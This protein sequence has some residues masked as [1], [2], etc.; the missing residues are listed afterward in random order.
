MTLSTWNLGNVTIRSRHPLLRL[1]A[2]LFLAFGASCVSWSQGATGDILGTVTNGAGTPIAG[3][4][5]TLENLDTHQVHTFLSNDRGTYAFTLLEPGTY[6]LTI[7]GRGLKTFLNPRIALLAGDRDRLDASLP[8]GSRSQ[9]VTEKGQRVTAQADN[10][11]VGA[12]VG[13]KAVADLPVNSPNVYL[14][15]QVSP[16]VN[17]G[18]PHSL[19][20]GTR[21]VDRRASASLSANGQSE[22]FNNNLIDGLDN[23]ERW[24]GLT[25][26]R[27]APEAIQSVRIDTSSYLADVSRTAGAVVN[28]QTK[29]GSNDLHG[30]IYEFFRN[31]I[32]DARPYF[33]R[34]SVISRSP[35]YD[36]NVFGGSVGGPLFRDKTF[37]FVDLQE[38][39]QVNATGQ[40]TTSTVP[41]LYEEQHPGDLSDIGGPVI[42]SIDPT[43]LSYF[44]LYPAPNQPGTLTSNGTYTN[45]FLYDPSRVQ[46]ITVGDLRIDHHFN[47]SNTLF[48]RYSYNGV[49]TF[50][51][52]PLPPVNGVYAGGTLVGTDPGNSNI[53]TDNG[54]LSYTHIFSARLAANLRAGYTL[55]QNNDTP[56]NY[57]TNLNNTPE[58]SV[59]NA[60]ACL[61]CSGL[62]VIT[63]APGYAP[64][65]D[66][67][68]IPILLTEHTYQYNGDLTYSMGNHTIK[69]GADLTRRL[70]SPLQQNDP[71]GAITFLGTAQTALANFFRGTPFN[72]LRQNFL[73]KPHLRTWEPNAFIQDAWR[74]N[75]RLT[76]NL[77]IRYDVYS[78][79]S[80]ENGNNADINLTT[81]K[82]VISPTAGVGTRYSNVAPRFGFAATVLPNTVVRGGYGITFFASDVQTAF[83]LLN[84]P[85]SYSSGTVTSKTPLS[86]GIASPAAPSATALAGQ[87]TAK[88]FNFHDAYV[89]QFNLLLQRDFNGN[90]FTVGYVGSLGRHLLSEIPNFN[91][92]APS[93]SSVVPSQPFADVLP[94]V[95]TID[96]WGDFASSSYN[97]LQASFQRRFRQGL[98]FNANYT[99]AHALD[100]EDDQG[101][102]E[103]GYGLE[104]TKASTYDYGNSYLDVR[105]HIAVTA[106]YEIPFANHSGRLMKGIFAGWQANVLSFWQTGLPFSITS[107]VTQTANS[108]GNALAYTNLNYVTVD[109]PNR[110][111]NPVLS[112]SSPNLFFNVAAFARQPIGTAGDAGRNILYGP[113]QRRTDL[114]LS[115]SFPIY[116]RVTGLFRVEAFNIS[117]TPDFSP[118]GSQITA[119]Q[120]NANGRYV[121]TTAGGFG[122]ITAIT[123]SSF[124]RELQFVMKIRF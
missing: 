24:N 118:P 107:A 28:I 103:V 74:A 120:E 61:D 7:T 55:L 43:A 73:E 96:Y 46:N 99:W 108:T 105:H 40:V 57:G 100:D 34:T 62:A 44:K 76:L 94:N 98:A 20:S 41:T 16:G 39:R 19:A 69:A 10:T 86:Q 95:N 45:N 21:P 122:V 48:A 1:V 104:P 8:A 9:T 93:G 117:N 102:Q 92:P 32:T 51:P 97:S 56:D 71:E 49:S 26:L 3:A 101:D 113:H 18:S 42:T 121:A 31:G 70:V 80:E 4:Q 47:G 5:V 22:L 83:N 65:G 84:P 64:L 110:I 115:K 50:I 81:G 119:Y 85:Y 87:L 109:R 27:P 68:T 79:P 36:Q 77:G 114:S 12:S 123:P 90:V 59:P 25:L 124:G 75:R 78:A 2:L 14:L 89:E 58:Y 15:A 67:T 11:T 112:N 17:L 6:S 33:V 13:T 72:Y 60:N 116:E 88:P 54:Q 106:N 82:L 53:K 29:S 66:A 23:N 111:A 37:F 63:P 30:S 91:L 35:V 52:G 38:F